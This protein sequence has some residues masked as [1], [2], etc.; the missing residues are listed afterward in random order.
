[1]HRD[2]KINEGVPTERFVVTT[3]HERLSD[4]Y[5][6]PAGGGRHAHQLLTPVAIGDTSVT[7]GG[8][9][10]FGCEYCLGSDVTCCAARQCDFTFLC[11]KDLC[12]NRYRNEKNRQSDRA[13]A[14]R[15]KGGQ[16]GQTSHPCPLRWLAGLWRLQLFRPCCRRCNRGSQKRRW[17]P[18][19][20]A[21]VVDFHDYFRYFQHIF[22][23]PLA[24]AR[25]GLRLRLG[26]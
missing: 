7:G 4:S 1:M 11:L 23:K 18:C 24:E 14:G 12:H 20:L 8:C 19:E 10:C 15:T 9:S 22:F 2:R 25:P 6:L 13:K 5:S 3:D 26:L 16:N 21:Q 17:G